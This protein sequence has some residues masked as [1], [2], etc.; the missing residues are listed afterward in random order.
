[1]EQNGYIIVLGDGG[2]KHTVIK[3]GRS[4]NEPEIV[5][6]FESETSKLQPGQSLTLVFQSEDR[7]DSGVLIRDLRLHYL[8]KDPNERPSS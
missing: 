7:G 4:Q 5:A 6:M 2:G 1:M 3:T 8:A